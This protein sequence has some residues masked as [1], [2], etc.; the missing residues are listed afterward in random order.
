[1]NCT[2][3]FGFTAHLQLVAIHADKPL[4]MKDVSEEW[5]WWVKEHDIDFNTKTWQEYTDAVFFCKGLIE[6]YPK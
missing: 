5:N 4:T 2:D 6:D 3:G 1:M